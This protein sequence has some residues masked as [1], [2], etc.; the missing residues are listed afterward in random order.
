MRHHKTS[1]KLF[2]A[3]TLSAL[4]FSN[5][6]QSF[7]AAGRPIQTVD[8]AAAI[9]GAAVVGTIAYAAGNNNNYRKHSNYSR[10]R[11]YRRY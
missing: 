3:A 10:K 5:C 4:V 9:V 8:P 11:G 2:V 6:V 7:D 1:I